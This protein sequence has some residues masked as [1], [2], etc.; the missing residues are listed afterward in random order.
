[1]AAEQGV[2]P[3]PQVGQLGVV[4]VAVQADPVRGGGAQGRLG[5]QR[6]GDGLGRLVEPAAQVQVGAESGLTAVGEWNP[7]DEVLADVPTP[8]SRTARSGQ[9]ETNRRVIR[10]TA[11]H[12]LWRYDARR[13]AFPSAFRRS[14][15]HAGDA[16]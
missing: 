5:L 9:T 16:S 10:R 11:A 4:G 12:N 2:G 15:L 7:L 8:R 13:V 14:P 3:T 6:V 1:M